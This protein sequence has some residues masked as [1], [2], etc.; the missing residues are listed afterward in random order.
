[1]QNDDRRKTTQEVEAGNG[2]IER[3]PKHKILVSSVVYD[4]DDPF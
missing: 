4:F 1:M 2:F 3:I